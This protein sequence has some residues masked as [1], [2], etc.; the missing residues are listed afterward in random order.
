MIIGSLQTTLGDLVESGEGFIQTGPFGSQLHAHDYAENGIP[1]VMPQQLGDNEISEYGIAQI[2][3]QDRDRLIRHVM[4]VGDIV[5]S[6]RGDVTRRA[7]ITGKE[8]GW[9]CGTGCLLL[10][11]NH[12]Q[13]D[14]RYLVRFLGLHETRSYLTQH[15]IGATM[16]NLN[17]RILASVPVVLPPREH[18]EQIIRVISAYDDLIENNRRRI[19]LLEQTA[20]LLYKEWFVHLRFPGHE[21]VKIKAGVPEGWE[22]KT[23]DE[24]ADITMG[25]SPKSIYYNE[26]GNGLPF[27]QGVT[28]FGVRFPSHQT[29]CTVQ[30]RLAE[31]G[32]ILFSVR[33][34]VGRINITTNKIV[35]GRGLA[36]I[37]SNRDQQN[38]LFYALKNHFFKEDM[39]GGGAIFAAVTKKDLHGVELLQALDRVAE[40][41]M[42]HIVPIDLQIEKLH[43]SNEQLIK[44]RDL[45][46]P[47]LMNGKIT[48]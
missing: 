7:Y 42:E 36:S 8:D 35:I 13:C 5:F 16:P 4:R 28:D 11:L 18:Q 2:N 23:L 44:A 43:Q 38:F 6:R 47:R 29:Y 30:N 41:F 27:H 31:P 17:Q 14:N 37:R 26:D 9:L 19:Q 24:I 1:I 39:I 22:R 33:A 3:E 15:A 40:M 48:I 25:Q 12:P 45:L 46:L 21:H 34:P 20:R 10:R 32:D